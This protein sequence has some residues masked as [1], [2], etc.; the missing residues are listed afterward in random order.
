MDD[1]KR[2]YFDVLKNKYTQFNGRASRREYWT[3]YL[4]NVAIMLIVGI[5]CATLG[6]E[7]MLNVIYTVFCIA[8]FLPTFAITVRRL[9]DTDHSGWWI[10]LSLIPLLNLVVFAFTLFDGTHGSNRFGQDPKGNTI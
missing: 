7:K 1:I 8:T 5:I 2:I 6:A 10:L 3:F 4:T 9:H